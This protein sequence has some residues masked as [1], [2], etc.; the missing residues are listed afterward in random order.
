MLVA[1]R[2]ADGRVLRLIQAMLKAG[3]YGQGRDISLRGTQTTGS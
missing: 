3:S 2:V 1:Q